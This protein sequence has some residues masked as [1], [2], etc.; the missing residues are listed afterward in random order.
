[1]RAFFLTLL[2]L[3]LQLIG[4][5][6][7]SNEITRWKA[8]AK[9]VEII[10]DRWGIAHVYGATDADAVF[11]FLFA[12]CEDDFNRVE[13]NY[14]S[15][16]A[17]QAMVEG[18]SKIFHDLRTRL[19]YDTIQAQQLYKNAEPWLQKLCNAFSDGVN[20]YLYSHPEVKPKLITRFQPW[21]PF[22]FSEGSIGGDIES[23][24]VSRLKEFYD[25]A[26]A[27]AQEEEDHNRPV[28]NPEP[29]PRGSNGFAIAPS[30][31]ATGNALLLINPHTSFYFRPEIHVSS[32]EGLNAYGAVTW[33]QF[34]V[35]QGFNEFCGWMHTS[36]AAD[37]MDEFREKVITRNDSVFYQ[38]GQE[39]L[40]MQSK[41]ITIAFRHDGTMKT[42]TFVTYATHHGPVIAKDGDR[43]I[44]LSMMREPLKALTQS[45]LRT[46]SKGFADYKNT[47]ELKTNSSNNTVFA[48]NT[49]NIAYW[50]GNFI[51]KRDA[52]VD[53]SGQVDGTNPNNDW[54]GLHELNEMV[55]VYNPANGWIQNC[56]STPFSVAAAASPQKEKFPTYMAP[57][58]ENARG[59]H[60][61]LVL[62]KA[63]LFTLDGLIAAAYDPYLPGFDGLMP[64]LLEALDKEARP[65]LVAPANELRNWDRK[66]S[67]SS[68]AT[69]LAMFWG[70]ELRQVLLARQKPGL[71]QLTIINK[72]I[73][74]TSDLEKVKAFETAVG[75]LQR[76]FGT[77]QVAWG[78]VN[79]FQ[80]LTGKVNEEYDDN[81]LSWAVPYASS[82]WGSLAAF[83]ARK[84]PG[85]KKMYGYVGNSF[86]AVVEFGKRVKAKS[87][88]AGG[89]NNNPASSF[90]TNQ[91]EIYS[92][93]NFK[94]VLFYREDVE[95]NVS[96][97]YQPGK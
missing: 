66:F 63:D 82:F 24:S 88:L 7:S 42:R 21:M 18:E 27:S 37:C 56:N 96:R 87:L 41:K 75:E 79:R 91:A 59:I 17:R 40:P 38:F 92:Q 73:R 29:E 50:H 78:D 5:P 95:R 62:N 25:Q 71:D 33:G 94:D 23:I 89:V 90:F 9:R 58:A 83:G 16:T 28:P 30:R 67:T 57:D 39:T 2:L 3:P 54:K 8:Q 19:F 72:M 85:T 52:T 81:K 32:R 1:M 4:Q 53:Y 45:F 47:M 65:A 68:V 26:Q 43:W 12:Q 6:F 35:Y 22:L 14:I 60:A 15:A 61:N 69:T 76:D 93:G 31:S 46:K 36:S 80:R 97:K 49:G 55:H 51:P 10:R 84:Y 20:Y 77:W 70:Q 11:G 74:E 13:L 34:F 64:A 44:T 86:V 48:D